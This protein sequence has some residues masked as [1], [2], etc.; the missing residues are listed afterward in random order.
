MK[1]FVVCLLLA[2]L[3]WAP[4][5]T[6]RETITIRFEAEV[7][8]ITEWTGVFDLSERVAIGDQVNGSFSYNPDLPETRQPPSQ[9]WGGSIVGWSVTIADET[10]SGRR[11]S[12]SR[13]TE[14]PPDRWSVRVGPETDATFLG[15]R[16]V[17]GVAIS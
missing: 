11:G 7:T 2:L 15:N 17:D 6:S 13:N 16:Y 4:D 14:F 3:C 8:G 1:G 9:A 5:A 12:I 10:L